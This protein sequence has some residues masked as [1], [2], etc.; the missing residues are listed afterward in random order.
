MTEIRR[1]TCHCGAVE[2]QVTGLS[3]RVVTF[4]HFVINRTFLGIHQNPTNDKSI[5]TDIDETR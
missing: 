2:F 4:W 5:S 3:E 1:G